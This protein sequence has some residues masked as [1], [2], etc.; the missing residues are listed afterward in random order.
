M[1]T[2]ACHDTLVMNSMT[3]QYPIDDAIHRAATE[4]VARYGIQIAIEQATHR[5]D[6]FANAGR[7]PEHA[8]A[9]RVL[10]MVE[11]IGGET[12]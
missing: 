3:T 11:Q 2:H 7:W 4:L 9:M 1:V 8:T 6:A 5:A 10:T 12:R